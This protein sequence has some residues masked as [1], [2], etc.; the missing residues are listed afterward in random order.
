MTDLRIK[1]E[2]GE[3]VIH[4]EEFLSW[5]SIAKVRKLLKIIKGSDTPEQE[6]IFKERIK[7]LLSGMVDEKKAY[8]NKAVEWGTRVAEEKLELEKMQQELERVTAYRDGYKKNSLPWKNL[9]EQVKKVKSQ[10][11]HQKEKI[12]FAKGWKRDYTNQFKT[13]QRNEVFYKKLLSEIFS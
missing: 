9:N 12:R 13:V 8:A 4:L 5:R 7:E 2:H 6:E 3:M 11:K 10:L 1:Y